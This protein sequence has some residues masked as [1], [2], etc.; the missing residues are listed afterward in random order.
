VSAGRLLGLAAAA[1]LVGTAGI[2]AAPKKAA[3]PAAAKSKAAATKWVRTVYPTAEGGYR[4]GNPAAPLKLVEY[5]S[6]TCSTCAVFAEQGLPPLLRDHVAT[7]RVSFEYRNF[8]RDPFDMA[9]ALVA[10]CSS[11]GNFFPVAERVFQTRKSWVGRF[12][13]MT[14]EQVRQ[15]DALPVP[16]RLVRYAEIGGLIGLAAQHGVPAAKARQCLT[17]QAALD[18]LVAMRQVALNR[19]G[20]RG[21]PHFILNGRNT[22]AYDWAS[23]Q[24]LLKAPGG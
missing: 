9:A 13:A 3:A 23:L 14:E 17:D 19:L 7:G 1:A 16:E 2:A 12:N 8:V 21:T 4:I 5:G 18:R 20:L 22:E 24:P 6:F 10:R 15:V 11:P